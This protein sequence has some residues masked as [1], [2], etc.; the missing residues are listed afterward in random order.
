MGSSVLH[1]NTKKM[2]GQRR[3]RSATA[4][5]ARIGLLRRILVIGE[6]RGE[7]EEGEEG[8]GEIER[9]PQRI[10]WIRVAP[11]SRTRTETETQEPTWTQTQI[12][13][14]AEH[15]LPRTRPQPAARSTGAAAALPYVVH[16]PRD[17]ETIHPPRTGSAQRDVWA[18]T[19]TDE[20]EHDSTHDPPATTLRTLEPGESASGDE[21]RLDAL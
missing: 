17:A 5:M 1:A 19:G 14:C 16:R 7:E 13:T 21:A 8:D 12:E 2:S 20:H 11:D 15:Q 3:P 4:P 18:S 9:D 10:G 6:I